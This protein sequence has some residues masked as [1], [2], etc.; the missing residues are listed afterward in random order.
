MLTHEQSTLGTS[1]TYKSVVHR[2][3]SICFHSFIV[4]CIHS[5]H[6]SVYMRHAVL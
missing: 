4:V 6:S 2:A 1:V 5:D 3:L